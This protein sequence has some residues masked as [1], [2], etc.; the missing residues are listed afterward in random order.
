[1]RHNQTK[2]VPYW[3]DQWFYHSVINNGCRLRLTAA[4]T[5][6]RNPNRSPN[7]SERHAWWVCRG[8]VVLGKALV[9][10]RAHLRKFADAGRS[11]RDALWDVVQNLYSSTDQTRDTCPRWCRLD[12]PTLQ[13]EPDHVDHVDHTDHTDHTDQGY[14]CPEISRSFKQELIYLSKVRKIRH[15]ASTCPSY[16]SLPRSVYVLP[17]RSS[18]SISHRGVNHLFDTMAAIRGYMFFPSRSEKTKNE[19]NRTAWIGQNRN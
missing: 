7:R 12:G 19:K 13:H 16:V 18:L 5:P 6:T 10:M 15:P 3:V 14:I 11:T 4:T 17:T 1:M 2:E 8:V 9:A